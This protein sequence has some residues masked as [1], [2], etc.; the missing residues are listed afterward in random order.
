MPRR[1]SEVT[2]TQFPFAPDTT[3]F[4]L[5]VSEHEGD[6]RGYEHAST[7]DKKLRLIRQAK[8]LGDDGYA[9]TL[10]AI[11]PGEKHSDVFEVDDLDAALSAMGGTRGAEK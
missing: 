6:H 10:L 1:T 4:V 9:C 8:Q 7:R 2:D 3:A 5:V 11:W